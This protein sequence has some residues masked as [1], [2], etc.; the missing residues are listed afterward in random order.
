MRREAR[1]GAL[2]CLAALS[3]SGAGRPEGARTHGLAADAVTTR[4]LVAG[5][6]FDLRTGLILPGAFDFGDFTHWSGF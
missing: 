5:D 3:A 6:R 1:A 4:L 2:L